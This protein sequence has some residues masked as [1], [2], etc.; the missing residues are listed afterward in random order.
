MSNNQ[1]IADNNNPYVNNNKMAVKDGLFG[2]ILKRLEAMTSDQLSL[3]LAINTSV[4]ALLGSEPVSGDSNDEMNK[5]ETN[6]VVSMLHQKL[7]KLNAINA[8]LKNIEKRLKES[9]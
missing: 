8:M 6:N 4:N 3:V 9:I 1:W 7:D 5:R 2:T